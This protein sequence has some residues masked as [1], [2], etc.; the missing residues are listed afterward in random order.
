MNA[1]QEV[2]PKG[3]VPALKLADGNLLNEGAATLQW[4][5]DQAPDSGLAPANGTTE[6]YLLIN[7]LNFLASELHVSFG[8]LFYAKTEEEKPPL[9][10][11]VRRRPCGRICCANAIH[12]CGRINPDLPHDSCLGI[13]R[14]GYPTAAIVAGRAW[15]DSNHL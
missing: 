15:R 5:A 2:N 13:T 4:I 6:R 9:R 10:E 12:S 7:S 11:R 8:P 3:N 14:G 1:W